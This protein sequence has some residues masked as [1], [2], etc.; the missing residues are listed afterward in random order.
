MIQLRLPRSVEKR[1]AKVAQRR[2]RTKND[3]M[4]EAILTYLEDLEDVY[5]AERIF[6]RVVSGKERTYPLEAVVRR[7]R[8]KR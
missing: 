3:I 1:L 6:A 8:L 7:L 5:E 2:N 4:Q